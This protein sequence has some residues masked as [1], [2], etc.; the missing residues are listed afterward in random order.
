[1][2]R[3]FHMHEGDLAFLENAMP[4]LQVALGEAMNRPEVNTI[5]G[6]VKEIL[7]NVRWDYGPHSE[8]TKL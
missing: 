2:S 5:M 8:V 1:M 7:S 4:Q 6:E 3:L